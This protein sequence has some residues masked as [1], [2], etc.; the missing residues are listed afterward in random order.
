MAH[1]FHR[2]YSRPADSQHTTLL[3]QLTKFNYFKI[4]LFLEREVTLSRPENRY[5]TR[6]NH[7]YR[8]EF[9]EPTPTKIICC[10]VL[11]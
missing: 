6:V 7:A 11:Q 9:Q 2:F 4:L 1:N 10:N 3:L 5:F 8:S